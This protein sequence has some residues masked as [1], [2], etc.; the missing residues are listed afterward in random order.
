MSTMS[1]VFLGFVIIAALGLF[2]VSVRMVK[3]WDAWRS[4]VVEHEQEMAAIDQLI[5]RARDGDAETPS[6]EELRTQLYAVLKNRGRV[7]SDARPNNVNQ[8]GTATVTIDSLNDG[9]VAANTVVYLFESPAAGGGAYLGEFK[10]SATNGQQLV[11]APTTTLRDADRRTLT[12]SQGPWKIYEQMPFDSYDLLADYDAAQLQQ[13]LPPGIADEF[14]KNGKPPAANDPEERIV[15][16]V[17]FL[18]DFGQL[19]QDQRNLLQ[20]LEIAQD[21]VVTDNTLKLYQPTASQLVANGVAEE[22]NRYYER[23]LRDFSVLFRE[24]NRQIPVWRDRVAA[25]QKDL[26]YLQNSVRISKEY[27]TSNRNEIASLTAE[28]DHLNSEVKFAQSYEQELTDLLARYQTFSQK[29]LEENGR[30]ADEWVKKQ[31]EAARKIDEATMAG[32]GQS[33]K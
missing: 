20:Q 9:E 11:L 6:I 15:M 25:G 8:D 1:K 18:K 17:K 3:T 30:L 27:E 19:S 24:F 22:M 29:V 21:V 33:G 32:L 4:K 26:M 2:Y 10:V 13:M 16:Q 5:K 31:E 12:A 7:W 28:R 23:P 14:A